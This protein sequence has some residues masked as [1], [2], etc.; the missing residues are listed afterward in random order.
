MVLMAS[1]KVALSPDSIVGPFNL[2]FQQRRNAST[3]E[4]SRDLHP[5][6]VN[7]PGKAI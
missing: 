2:N 3:G 1:F 4:R 5:F 6:L 7:A